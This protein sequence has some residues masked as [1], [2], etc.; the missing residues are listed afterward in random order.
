RRGYL[1]ATFGLPIAIFVLMQGF[2]FIQG[3]QSDD[4]AVDP[5]AILFD[6]EGIDTAGYVDES[7]LFLDVP[8]TMEG[9]LIRYDNEDSA[10]TA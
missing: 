7:G 4:T 3:L 2:N 1:F 6:F 5:T 8:D 10:R 9:R